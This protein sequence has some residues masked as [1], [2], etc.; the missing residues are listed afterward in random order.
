MTLISITDLN[1]RV[2]RRAR[3]GF[4]KG[5][6]ACSLH[7]TESDSRLSVGDVRIDAAMK[8]LH[9]ILEGLCREANLLTRAEPSRSEASS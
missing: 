5:K 1:L 6:H 2:G 7:V 3:E 9:S 4:K 8:N